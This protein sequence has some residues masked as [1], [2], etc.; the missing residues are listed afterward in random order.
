M[1]G[2]GEDQRGRK[3]L[4]IAPPSSESAGKRKEPVPRRGK[5]GKG[6]EEDALLPL[7]P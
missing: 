2:E 4:G 7:L 6:E 3:M 5:R 1:F